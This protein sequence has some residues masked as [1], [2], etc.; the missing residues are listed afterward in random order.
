MLK[1]GVNIVRLH[2]LTNR[3]KYY[4]TR[5]IF[6]IFS[7][8]RENKNAGRKTAIYCFNRLCI[9]KYIVLTENILKPRK[10]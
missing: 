8:L 5:V 6:T 4:S 7:K 3:K 9:H 1:N 10:F 2:K